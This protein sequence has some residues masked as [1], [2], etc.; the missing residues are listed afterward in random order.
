MDEFRAFGHS[1]CIYS[2]GGGVG[3]EKLRAQG[4]LEALRARGFEGAVVG[5]FEIEDAENLAVRYPPQTLNPI[6]WVAR[7]MGG[8]RT[9]PATR[10]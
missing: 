8:A 6:H 4:P 7:Y 10:I 5:G 9:P 2:C 1:Q 3:V